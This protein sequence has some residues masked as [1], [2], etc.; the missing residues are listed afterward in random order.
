MLFVSLWSLI[1]PPPQTTIECLV[2]LTYAWVVHNLKF[3]EIYIHIWSP[4]WSIGQ[5]SWLQIQ[6]SGFDSRR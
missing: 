6:K 5:G 3:L 2:M 1:L 4:L